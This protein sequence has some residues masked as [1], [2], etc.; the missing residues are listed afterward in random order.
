MA[1]LVYSSEKLGRQ[2]GP[3]G[4]ALKEEDYG[5]SDVSMGIEKPLRHS[6]GRSAKLIPWDGQAILAQ[7]YE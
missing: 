6:K 2:G 3:R 5:K 4:P 7:R 1:R